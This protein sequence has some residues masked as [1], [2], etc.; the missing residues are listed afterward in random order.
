MTNTNILTLLNPY[1][2]SGVL[3][4]T[5]TI[6]RTNY[7]FINDGTVGRIVMNQVGLNG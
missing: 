3:T 2:N 7:V 1:Q 5:P 4:Y 6:P